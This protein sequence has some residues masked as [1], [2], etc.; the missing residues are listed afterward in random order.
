M[1]TSEV[2]KA[3]IN[4]NKQKIFEVEQRVWEN[5]RDAYATRSAIMENRTMI[6]RNYEAAFN[7]NRQLAN[8]NTDSILR[9]RIQLVKNL[10]VG[11]DAV[12]INFREAMVNKVKLDFL[13]HRA[14]L[15]ARVNAVND[16]LASIGV[17]LIKV[18]QEIMDGNGVIVGWNA[19]G[20]A[21][22]KQWIDNGVDGFKT[23]T[24]ESNAALI[25]SNA[26]RIEELKKKAEEN[27][28]KNVANWEAAKVNRH[29]IEAN[30]SLIYARREEIEANRENIKRNFDKIAHQ[31]FQ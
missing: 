22:N 13:E 7:G 15:N 10:Q 30:S 23:A 25:K 6:Q 17:R 3:L 20:I 27:A 12:K 19:K 31:S 2:N 26:A 21:D 5:K 29:N 1:A 9:N 11:T 16:E 18:N 14:E 4:E 28:K 8:S 24:P